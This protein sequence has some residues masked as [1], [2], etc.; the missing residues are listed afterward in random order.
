MFD[1]SKRT[2]I[3][4]W[5]GKPGT[6]VQAVYDRN[7]HKPPRYSYYGPRVRKGEIEVK[8]SG[9]WRTVHFDTENGWARKVE[10]L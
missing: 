5:N 2:V 8:L 4:G 3:T 10:V 9:E 1:I 7:L 6:I